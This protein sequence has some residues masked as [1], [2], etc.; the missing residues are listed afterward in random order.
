MTA[1]LDTYK[2]R[3]SGVL[4]WSQLDSLWQALQAEDGWYLYEVGGAPPEASLSDEKLETAIQK[5][6]VFLRKEHDENYCGVVYAD[7]LKAPSLLKIY[8]PKK[9]GASCGSSGSTV[10]PK[11]T[12]SK[13]APIDLVSWA[14]ER[15]Q[16]PAWWK[17]MLK[18]VRQT[19]LPRGSV[20]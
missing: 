9:M 3:M 1:F 5:I 16:K 7:D 13:Q 10:L 4:R 12:L 6:E 11:W 8:H 2:G 17:H 18:P 19:R 20:K 14:L 15:D